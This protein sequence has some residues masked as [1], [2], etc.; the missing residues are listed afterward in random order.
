MR[1]LVL[2]AV[3]LLLLSAVSWMP[4]A[5]PSAAVASAG[6]LTLAIS[7]LDLSAFPDVSAIVQLGGSI[8]PTLGALSK[9]AFTLEVD[10]GPL[11]LGSVEEAASGA[12][13]PVQTVLLLDESGSMKGAAIASAAAAAGRFVSAMRPADTAAVQ[14]FNEGFRTLS[15]FS[16]DRAVLEGSLG[17]LEPQKETA[18]YDA[19]VKSFTSFGAAPQG[20][21]R[22]LI[23]LSDGGDTASKTTLD[24]T[25]AAAR[26]SGVKVYAIGLKTKEFDSEPLVRI[27]DASGGRYVETP[28]P[29]TLASL[30]EGLAEEIHNQYVLRFAI[31]QSR[32]NVAAGTLIVQVGA[33]GETAQAQRGFFYPEVATTTTVVA[34]VATTIP[35]DEPAESPLSLGLVSRFLDW[36]YSDYA[37]GL[38][39]FAIVFA[40]LYV[41]SGILFPRRNVLA[42]YGDL[43]ENRRDLGPRPVGE[44]KAKEGAAQRAVQRVLAV[45]GY[46]HP[47]QRL[48]DD[49]ALKFRASEFALLHLVAVV[50]VVV[51][52]AAV[53][54]PV[55][56]VVLAA[57]VIVFIPLLWLDLKGKARRR[58][59]ENQVPGTLTLLAGSLRAGQAFQQAIAVAASEAPEPT[60]AEL[61][62]VV[63]QQRLGVA[64]EEALRSVAERMQSEAFDWVVMTTIIQRQ[65]G[66]NLAEIYES[67]A[68]TLRE[69]MKLHRQI[70]TLTAEGRLSA[71]I[72]I[73]LPFAIAAMVAIVNRDY[74]SILWTNITGV[75]MLC[76]AFVLM[77]IGVLW[78]R[79]ISRLDV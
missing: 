29:A 79:S 63:S 78:M 75:V 40:L 35:G 8:A 55:A 74:L 70:R 50:V 66:G 2:I 47:L 60:A 71:I 36:E 14:A 33:G 39:L 76:V 7:S 26:A 59:F 73:I 38:V 46:Q 53:R 27:A 62:R 43:L 65:V 64:P 52:L 17:M 41:L 58:E 12:V 10:G 11:V 18:L 72:L 24:Q 77:V 69:R 61:R 42:E 68:H 25:V 6:D 67:T 44:P 21:A 30:Y 57:I 16:A 56:L 22:Y 15:A 31:P 5:G 51:I 4:I 49:A 45:R 1:V 19:L 28:D 13:L 54:I 9:D 34:T 48:I 23:L 20:A 37:V 32:P 3:A